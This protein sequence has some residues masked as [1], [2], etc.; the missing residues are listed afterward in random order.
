[1]KQKKYFGFL[2]NVFVLSL[3]SLLNDVVGE[4]I[5]RTTPL[6]LANA[7]AFIADVV[8]RQ[9]QGTAYGVYNMVV[10]VT[11]LPASLIAGYLWQAVNPAAA[12]YFGSTTAFVSALGL[13]LFL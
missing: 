10:G 11:L 6:Y 4:T 2:S 9:H 8:D 13:L 12:F 3:V 7:K 5:K 1:M